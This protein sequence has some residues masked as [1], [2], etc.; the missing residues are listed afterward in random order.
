MDGCE[1]HFLV[2]LG[3]DLSD[4]A[5]DFD[6][7]FDLDLDFA[8]LIPYSFFQSASW[9]LNLANFFRYVSFSFSFSFYERSA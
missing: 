4:L 3:F 2:F 7:D 5:L 8:S 1:N 9:S 6:L